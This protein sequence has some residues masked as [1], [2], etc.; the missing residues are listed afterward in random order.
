M[1]PFATALVLLAATCLVG[2][3]LA[4]RRRARQ[5]NKGFVVIA[6]R[7]RSTFRQRGAI[8]ASDFLNLAGEAPHIVSGHPDRH[9][10][11]IAFEADGE[12]WHAYL[13][14]E[15]RVTRRYR[16]ANLL[17]G[18]GFSSRSLR[19][20]SVLQALRRE[21]QP[22][23]EWMAAG[24]DGRGRAF[25]L[26]R[27]V[28]GVEL[29][30][31][32]KGETDR[33]RRRR[34]ARKLG[35]TLA[36]LHSAGY[37]HPDL[38]ANHVFVDATDESI[39]ILDWQ[40][41]G[42]SHSLSWRVCR[43]DLAALHATVD[44]TLAGEEERLLCLRAYWRSRSP[45]G[46]SWQSAARSVELKGKRLLGRRHICEKRQH[47][48]RPQAWIC[49]DGEALCVTPTL[50]D[51]LGER[52]PDYLPPP[53][54][55]ATIRRRWPRLPNAGQALLVQRN[56]PA[57]MG[58]L[59]FRSR[60][61]T[62]S[63]EQRQAALLLRLQR[64]NILA[65]Q[66]LALGQRRQRDGQIQS[67]LLAEP[68]T[69]A[70]ALEAW[71]ARQARRRCSASDS[72]QRRDVLR[73]TGSLLRRLHDASCYL[74]LDDAGCGLAVR[75]TNGAPSVV[76]DGIESVI[77]SR[78]RRPR[79]AA[80]DV[81][82]MRRI[83]LAASCSRTDVCRFHAGYH[84]S[85]VAPSRRANGEPSVR[86]ARGELLET[87]ATNNRASFWRRLFLGVRRW[88][89]RADWPRF[90]GA[91]WTERIMDQPVTDRFNAKQGRSTGRWI[92]EPAEESKRRT[93]RLSVFL[94]RHHDI[95]RW[96]GWLA[97][98]WPWRAWSPAWQEWR[99]LLWARR[100]GMNVPRAVAA[101]E[102][103]GP[104][105]KLRSVLAVE[106]LTGMMS[107]QEAI[108]LAAVRQEPEAF[109]LWKR[110]LAVEIARS[111][112]MLHDRR[113]F[114]K[115]LYLCHFFISREDTRRIPPKG[116]RGRV[117]MIDLHRLGHHALL[118]DLW[119]TKDIA[120]LLY[121]SYI[122]GVDGRDRLAFWRA[123]RGDGPHRPRWVWL[124]RFILYRWR[125]YRRHNARNRQARQDG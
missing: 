108:P 22:G 90:A 25:L 36:R 76:V 13:K 11:R 45:F 94:K 34:I 101:A 64:H 122:L 96:R 56:Q 26:L 43:R 110:S 83:L 105:G 66:V 85:P 95:P 57:A 87:A 68:L 9:V 65:P 123:Y 47:P 18:F 24:D 93:R 52:I 107:L 72:A 49:L 111:T 33:R 14:C 21:D 58:R 32:L 3:L 59:A 23:P 69:D 103:L 17:T 106:E 113:C 125:R 109:R 40:R 79:R 73:Q 55:D 70:C 20:A 81:R 15:H 88:C 89:Q 102:F 54:D 91:D 98:V 112:R 6:P 53:G 27:E 10:A 63:P 61:S 78:R 77:P 114:H 62:V 80:R 67:F 35:R 51:R 75:R 41:A 12:T 119:K 29:R 42:L 31:Y 84:S 7:Y 92:L 37:A 124:R 28:P 121:S 8:E 71:L 120:Q 117:S 86:P 16:L 4:I 39:H 115:D 48:A 100:Q 74:V 82:R 97:T 99:H 1:N 118:G 19:E 104:W 60:S 46:V 44:D 2:G 30:S 50:Y 38:Y 116:W 5:R